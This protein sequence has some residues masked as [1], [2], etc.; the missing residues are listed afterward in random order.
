V[1]AQATGLRERKKQAT[2]EALV[3]AGLELFVERGY[4]ET[5]L[6]EIADAA[7]VS[8]RTIFAYFPSKEDIL[9]ANVQT[10]F[11]ALDRA[12]AERPAGT[13]TLSALRAFILSSAHEKTELDHK[14]GKVIASDSTLLSHRRAR[15]GQLQEVIAAAMAVDLG[16][17]PE[18]R[19]PLIAAASL[20]A[21]FELLEQ[22]DDCVPWKAATNEEI[23]AAIDPVL[24]FIRAGL[25]A[26]P[27]PARDRR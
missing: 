14:V 22:Q 12:L 11:D 18:D 4:D 26:L 5:T 20:T 2:R 27:P 23:A 6:A 21:A 1:N 15:L 3:R 16:V 13:D 9:F 25:E 7:G 10:M 17:G 24:S 19:R 8:P